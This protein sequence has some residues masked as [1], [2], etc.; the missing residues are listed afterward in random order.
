[1]AFCNCNVGETDNVHRPDGDQQGKKD[2]SLGSGGGTTMREKTGKR[3]GWK[4]RR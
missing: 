2:K 1:M 4:L 3:R